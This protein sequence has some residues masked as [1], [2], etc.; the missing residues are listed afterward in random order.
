MIDTVLDE[1]DEVEDVEEVEEVEEVEQAKG[2]PFLCSLIHCR[3][4]S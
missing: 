1:V 3:T 4:S 2:K